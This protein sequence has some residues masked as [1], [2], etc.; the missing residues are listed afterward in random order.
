[1]LLQYVQSNFGVP[2]NSCVVDEIN[3]E[4]EREDT[5]DARNKIIL[6]GSTRAVS[7]PMVFLHFVSRLE[8]ACLQF[9]SQIRTK[10]AFEI[11][12]SRNREK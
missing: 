2:C 1:M 6:T 3:R 8:Y 10:F 5:F 9:E 11:S 7:I 4:C 12:C